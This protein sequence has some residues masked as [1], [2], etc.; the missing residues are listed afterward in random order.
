MATEAELDVAGELGAGAPLVG[1][2]SVPVRVPAPRW[3]YW[4]ATWFGAGRSPIAPG[5]VGTLAALPCYFFLSMLRQPLAIGVVLALALLGVYAAEIVA[6]DLSDDDPQIVVVD[7]TVSV[8]LALC[9]AVPHSWWAVLAVVVTFRLLDIYKPG[10]I[11][12]AERL[13]P[14]GLGIMADDLVAGLATGLVVHF[15]LL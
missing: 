9:I 14:A 1:P 3:A 7:E 4:Y 11:R 8:L 12:L 2:A 13:K 5:T 15:T 10:P 6:R